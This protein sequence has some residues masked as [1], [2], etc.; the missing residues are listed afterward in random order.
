MPT[1]APMIV[2]SEIGVSITR[3]RAELLLQPAVLREDAAAADVLAERDDARIGAH[4]L[5]QRGAGGLR[6]GESRHQRHRPAPV[7]WM[8]L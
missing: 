3:S 2:A 8:S 5:G 7:S 4:R 1:A 6:V